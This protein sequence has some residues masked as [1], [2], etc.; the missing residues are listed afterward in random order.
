MT[1]PL[2]L[3]VNGHITALSTVYGPQGSCPTTV[4]PHL[5]F[6]DVVFEPLGVEDTCLVGVKVLLNRTASKK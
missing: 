4:N 3:I 5:R 6:R 1:V 2:T